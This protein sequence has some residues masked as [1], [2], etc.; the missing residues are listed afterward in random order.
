MRR[1][2]SEVIR[3]LEMRI[4]R[5]EKQAYGDLKLKTF[6]YSR[7]LNAYYYPIGIVK[8]GK[9]TGVQMDQSGEV[10]LMNYTYDDFHYHEMKE[11][12]RISPR[13]E[14]KILDYLRSR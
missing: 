5:L 12:T 1:L 7:K 6:Y 13:D 2:A 10:S 8:N 4:A 3:D 14:K 9:I 11:D